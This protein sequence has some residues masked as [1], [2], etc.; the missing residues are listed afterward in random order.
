MTNLTEKEAFALASLRENV[1]H[2]DGTWG[3][4][5]L[6]NAKPS[7]WETG[8][9]AGVLG[10]LQKKGFYMPEWENE[11]LFGNVKIG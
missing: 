3:Q 10:N 11:G 6:D 2:S 5:Y 9:W 7:V 4:V 1:E 8:T